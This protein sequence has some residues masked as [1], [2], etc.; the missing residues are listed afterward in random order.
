MIFAHWAVV[1]VA[2]FHSPHAC[3]SVVPLGHGPFAAL[4]YA[5]TGPAFAAITFDTP[6]GS[7]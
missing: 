3:T 4:T 1:P 6:A 2:L 7:S 5:P